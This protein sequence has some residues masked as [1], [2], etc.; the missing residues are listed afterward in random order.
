MAGIR[1][2]QKR[3]LS[4]EEQRLWSRVAAT[5]EALHPERANGRAVAPAI[6]PAAVSNG[7]GAAV[8]PV[9]PIDVPPSNAD[10][11]QPALNGTPLRQMRGATPAN[12]H[13]HAPRALT[14]IIRAA[15]DAGPVGR[16]EPGLDR[17]TADRLRKGSREPDAR[18]DLHGM[19]AERAHLA[20]LRFVASGIA[21]HDRL[22]LVVT[23]KGRRDEYGHLTERGILRQSL[24]GWLHSSPLRSSIIGIYQAHQ[25]HG[26]AGAFYIYLKRPRMGAR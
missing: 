16:R 1:R 3:R 20:C 12:G 11:I 2:G 24:A 14:R 25:K 18:L 22:L 10:R 9:A 23:G 21:R 13:S 6:M 17:R 4:A 5:A 8:N 15:P 26:G 19:T 7:V